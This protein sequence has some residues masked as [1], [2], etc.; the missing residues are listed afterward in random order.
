MS[1]SQELRVLKAVVTAWER[2]YYDLF[3]DNELSRRDFESVPQIIEAR[4][5]I[6]ASQGRRRARGAP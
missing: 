4:R 3:G 1:E 6:A 2:E 5:I